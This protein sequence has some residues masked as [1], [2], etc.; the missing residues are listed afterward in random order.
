MTI[1]RFLNGTVLAAMLAGGGM[2]LSSC[3]QYDL[4]ER[5]PDGWGSSIYNWLDE[6]GNYRN[7]VR[8]IEDLG[9]H[10]VLAK[11]GSKTLF[12]ADD[13][14]YDRF[15]QNNTW[16]V[17]SYADLSTSQKN[18]APPCKKPMRTI[19]VSGGGLSASIPAA[20]QS[21]VSRARRVLKSSHYF[22]RGVNLPPSST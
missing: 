2:L 6:A 18:T 13:A 16:G 11:T 3:N 22:R 17:K 12:V 4:D 14:A 9:Y 15:F 10:E 19:E 21:S 5:T 20:F 7:T 1:K 8:I